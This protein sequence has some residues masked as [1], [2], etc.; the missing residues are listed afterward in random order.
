[1]YSSREGKLGSGAAGLRSRGR[2]VS[3]PS[4]AAVGHVL[5]QKHLRSTCDRNDEVFVFLGGGEKVLVRSRLVCNVMPAP[6]SS[7]RRWE[8]RVCLLLL[9]IV[10]FTCPGINRAKARTCSMLSYFVYLRCDAVA[11]RGDRV[12]LA[13]SSFHLTAT[14]QR[15]LNAPEVFT[16]LS[17]LCMSNPR[18][19]LK[20]RRWSWRCVTKY[21]QGELVVE[22]TSR[23]TLSQASLS[24][25]TGGWVAAGCCF[26]ML[27][28]EARASSYRSASAD[29]EDDNPPAASASTCSSKSAVAAGAAGGVAATADISLPRDEG[30]APAGSSWHPGSSQFSAAAIRSEPSVNRYRS[31]VNNLK[32]KVV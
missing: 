8:T 3:L 30:A 12:K 22:R 6:P 1:M 7:H 13:S 32:L 28:S 21:E 26:S 14:G 27:P 16:L 29:D 9:H 19:R 2:R 18:H 17:A 10:V 11:A 15:Y 23:A 31:C 25:S 5:F 24:V 20:S 4:P